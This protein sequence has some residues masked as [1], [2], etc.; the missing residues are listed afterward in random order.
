MIVPGEAD[1]ALYAGGDPGVLFESHDGGA[2]WA[3][4]R[5]ALGSPH[6]S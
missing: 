2:T 6:P 4:N 1:Q 3:L 5:G